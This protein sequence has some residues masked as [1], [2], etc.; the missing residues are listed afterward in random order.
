MAYAM[1]V[2]GDIDFAVDVEIDGTPIAQQGFNCALLGANTIITPA[3]GDR[4]KIYRATFTPSANIVGEVTIQLGAII[5]SR[6][7]N[8]QLGAIYGFNVAPNFALGVTNGLLIVNLPIATAI[9]I[10]VCWEE[11]LGA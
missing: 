3:A 1:I 11:V 9:D 10:D 6:T 2:K 5:L 4:L 7:Y 8:P